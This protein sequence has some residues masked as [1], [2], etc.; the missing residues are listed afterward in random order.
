LFV[1]GIDFVLLT[2]HKPLVA[3]F[4][5]RHKA[6]N[7]RLE[8]WLLNLQPYT[9]TV[10]HIPG[11]S[12]TADG[13]SRLPI[14]GS[15]SLC[16][17]TEDF[18]FSVISEAVPAAL[19]REDIEQ[20]SA[21]DNVLK[22]IRQ[23]IGTGEWS[24][25]SGSAY[26]TVRN[27][28]WTQGDIVMRNDRI[29]IPTEMQKTVL[30]LA[31]EGHQ[32][33]TRTKARLRL[34]TWWPTMNSEA[35]EFIRACHACQLVG[36]RP[37]PEPIKSTQLPEGPWTD[38]AIDLCGPLPN[39]DQLFVIVDYF[40]RWPEVIWLKNTS[41][42]TIIRCL[43]SVFQTH[44][45]PE[46]IRS[47]NGP[48][49]AS[50]EFTAFCDYLN[51]QHKKGIPYWPQSNGE[52]ER[53]NETMLKIVKIANAQK[54][55][56][57]EQLGNFLFQ[58][59]TTPHTTTGVSPSELLMGRKLRDKLPTLPILSRPTESDW[60]DL[61][62]Q[63]DARRKEQSKVYADRRRLAVESDIQ[64]GDKVLMPKKKD[65][66]LSCN[67]EE[68]PCVV[69]QRE[70]N[71][72]TVQTPDGVRM[73]NTAHVKRFVEKPVP[74]LGLPE[75]DPVSVPGPTPTGPDKTV[76]SPSKAA[77]VPVRKSS[78]SHQSPGWMKDFVIK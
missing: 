78:R 30:A 53:F 68:E 75:A 71:A 31:H 38:I 52:V 59:R 34:K 76:T 16:E 10:Q 44:G 11:K 50:Q 65:N 7:A 24:S 42:K 33:M 58:Y 20:A 49:F 1:Y 12:N 46:T 36:S 5:G 37:R 57:K 21:K 73:R 2:D 32:G 27:E 67:F 28:L 51:V 35:E 66:K 43:E 8:R 17:Q 55:D 3:V 29:V 40:S 61:T 19:K 39:G 54:Q 72:V 74:T 70:G 41:T 48:Q 69:L 14:D 56:L 47:D 60:Q 6:P 23:A 15:D 45:L 63:R 62:R 18:A 9:F 77:E 64:P 4:N 26:F 13:L 22:L 25:L